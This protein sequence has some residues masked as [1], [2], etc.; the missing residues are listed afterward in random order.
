MAKSNLSSICVNLKV[1]KMISRVI[2]YAI[3]KNMG[4]INN[5]ACIAANSWYV[6]EIKIIWKYSIYVC[7]NKSNIM[8]KTEQM[9]IKEIVDWLYNWC[10]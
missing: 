9:S 8:K 7:T 4:I 2:Q 10:L 1:F 5:S 6:V 3:Y